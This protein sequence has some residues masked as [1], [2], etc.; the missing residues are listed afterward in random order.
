MRDRDSI[1]KDLSELD[2][3]Q[4]AVQAEIQDRERELSEARQSHHLLLSKHAGLARKPVSLSVQRERIKSLESEIDDL[5]GIS[6]D[7]RRAELQRE[8]RLCDAA[9]GLAT[10]RQLADQ[11]FEKLSTAMKILKD[12][13]EG[14][15]RL[16]T[17]VG[18]L[19]AENPVASLNSIF[20]NLET[21]PEDDPAFDF[22]LSGYRFL[23][24]A[25]LLEKE[26]QRLAKTTKSLSDVAFGL[27]F[28][29]LKNLR[30]PSRKPASSVEQ[31]HPRLATGRFDESD[32]QGKRMNQNPAVLG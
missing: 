18:Q 8:L 9:A 3:R 22:D 15:R 29:T 23:T 11:W 30:L 13:A 6:F 24:N 16:E 4:R 17:I 7:D 28:N 10:Y 19:R 20:G 27:E 5:R 21:I 25:T 2:D 14:G 12:A 32:W 31:E 26:I 1:L